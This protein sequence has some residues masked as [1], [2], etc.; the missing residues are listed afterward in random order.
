MFNR[1]RA[2]GELP[3]GVAASPAT[4]IGWPRRGRRSP[5]GSPRSCSTTSS[6]T[7]ATGAMVD[8]F[9][10][11]ARRLVMVSSCDVYR[12]YGRLTGSEPGADIRCRSTRTLRCARCPT[13]TARA[14]PTPATGCTI[15]TRSR[16]SAPCSAPGTSRH[17]PAPAD[18]ARPER[19]PAPALRL[20]PADGRRRPAIVAPGRLRRWRSAY[21][22]ST[23]SP[24]HR[25]GGDRRA[26]RGAGVQRRRAGRL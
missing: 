7:S 2:P 12:A 5:A 6:S 17:G 16:P 22:T 13:P 26:R 24:R 10:G 21:A 23:T 9:R 14:T 20:C 25:P 1:G 4:S 8:V 15:T 11:V 18:G 3:A 19:L